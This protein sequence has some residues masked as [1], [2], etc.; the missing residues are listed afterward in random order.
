MIPV[1]GRLL[2]GLGSPY[3][4]DRLGWHIAEIVQSHQPPGLSIR[5]AMT[6]IALIDWLDGVEQLVICDAC[7]GGG[8][9][10]GAYCW[11][12]PDEALAPVRFSGSHDLE[13]AAVLGL[14]EQLGL[15]PP[16]VT[17][18]AIEAKPA[19]PSDLQLEK[20]LSSEVLAAVPALVELI[21]IELR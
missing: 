18:W 3:G 10:G 5:R 19:L 15:L 13:L 16:R 4:D 21:E 7:Q 12:W 20:D 8:W 6:P 1:K 17:I 9:P 14:A 2:V 11:H